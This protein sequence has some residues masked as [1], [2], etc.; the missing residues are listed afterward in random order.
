MS[1]YKYIVVAFDERHIDMKLCGVYDSYNEAVIATT[2]QIAH[3]NGYENAEE[4]EHRRGTYE[5]LY[6][7]ECIIETIDE[8]NIHMWSI[9]EIPIDNE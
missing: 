5:E 4:W 2:E 3:Y 8:G 7:Y 6:D 9:F 1:K